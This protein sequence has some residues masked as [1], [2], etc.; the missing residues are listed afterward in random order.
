M[1]SLVGSQN[2]RSKSVGGWRV[3]SGADEFYSPST[4]N[5]SI[6]CPGNRYYGLRKP[7]F[8]LS[9][10]EA[11]G[12]LRSESVQVNRIQKKEEERKTMKI[13]TT[14]TAASVFAA[15]SFVTPAFAQLKGAE[16]LAWVKPTARTEAAAP[17][18]MMCKTETRTSVDRSARGANKPVTV[19]TALVCPSCET[20]EVSKGAGKLATHKVEHTCKTAMA[21]CETKS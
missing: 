13:L 15:L 12:V 19:Y 3:P 4:G 20:K 11:C 8:P 14:L 5:H 9:D 6:V 18:K 16:K 1:D 10:F 21:C 17:H 2:P 7:V